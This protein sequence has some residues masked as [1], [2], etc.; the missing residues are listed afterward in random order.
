MVDETWKLGIEAQNCQRALAGAPAG[1]HSVCQLP[2]G[3]CLQIDPQT[4]KAVSVHSVFCSLIGLMM[5][6][7]LE[8]YIVQTKD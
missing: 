2:G 6:L 8:T 3:S 4:R 7:N 5:I 1:T